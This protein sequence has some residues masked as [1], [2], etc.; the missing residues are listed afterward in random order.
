M[1]VT[2]IPDDVMQW[3]RS[4]FMECNA[5]VTEKL[6]RNPNAPEESFD[7][8]WIEQLSRFAS[9]AMLD[10]GWAIKI[11]SHYLGGMRHYR[12]W[13]IAD[14]G[15][16]VF[17]RLGP[18]ER[19]SKLAL[20]QSKRLFPDGT[21]IREETLVDFE[22]GLARLADPEDSSLSVG[23]GAE[24]R[25]TEDSRYRALRAGSDQVL[26]ITEY[27]ADADLK[28]YYQ[29]YN[30]WSMP[31][32]QHVPLARY[33]APTG[34]PDLGVRVVPAALMHTKLQ[35]ERSPRLNELIE[36]DALPD[37]GWRLESFMCDE[38]LGCREGDEF[39]S[40]ADDRI[41]RLFYRRTGAIAAAIA[42]TIEAPAVTARS[43]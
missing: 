26:A 4:V 6:V 7:L 38:L 29:L 20:L 5:R 2:V 17:L 14:I 27:Q 30:P 10:S 21:P 22:T 35:G 37:H 12:R 39:E 11:E 43:A 9:P 25:F 23:F 42:I 1:N 31:F 8:T 41:Q 40:I 3:L 19:R 13:E 33:T 32:T 28:V 18:D 15:V 16:L 34:T 24:F 36:L